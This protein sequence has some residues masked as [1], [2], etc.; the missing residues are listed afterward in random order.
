QQ[1]GCA[2]YGQRNLQEPVR[3]HLVSSL[4]GVTLGDGDLGSV[5]FSRLD[6]HRRHRCLPSGLAPLRALAGSFA[7]GSPSV[8]EETQREAGRLCGQFGATAWSHLGQK[9]L[10]GPGLA[11]SLSRLIWK[12]KAI[13][14]PR[15]TVI[16]TR[17][18]APNA[19]MPP[20]GTSPG[21]PGARPART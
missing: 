14:A 10:A 4:L 9:W 1:E 8:S 3:G 12:W 11:R 16:V 5:G 19:P 2:E 15:A 6:V 7:N 20:N 13:A 17:T 18:P 21:R